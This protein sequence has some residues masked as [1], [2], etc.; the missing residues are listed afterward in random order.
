[1]PGA[2]QSRSG[3]QGIPSTP[4]SARPASRRRGPSPAT[5]ASEINSVTSYI[6]ASA[7]YG[8]TD[9]ITN[10]IRLFQYERGLTSRV[11]GELR[12]FKS[13][14]GQDLLPQDFNN[15]DQCRVGTGLPCFQA[16]WCT[17]AAT[18]R[19]EICTAGDTRVNQHLQLTGLHTVWMRY[20]NYVAR[21]LKKRHG[22]W[23]DEQL[24]QEAR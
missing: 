10:G 4:A 20:H 21:E 7:M 1:M 2:G 13:N 18:E 3:V 19:A 17:I 16:V 14:S 11:A 22:Q 15:L 8:S 24:F 9:T 5:R 12:V 23:S 6:D